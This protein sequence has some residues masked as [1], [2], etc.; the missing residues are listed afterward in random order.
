M[1][2]NQVKPGGVTEGGMLC[3]QLELVLLL[4]LVLVFVR[5]REVPHQSIASAKG[6]EKDEMR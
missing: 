5:A 2:L 4:V 6:Q 1:G 3:V